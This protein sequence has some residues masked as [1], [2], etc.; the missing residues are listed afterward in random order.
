MT[1]LVQLASSPVQPARL[2]T[3]LRSSRLPWH[4]NCLGISVSGRYPC[5]HR[6][7][8]RGY[9]RCS[10]S[11]ELPRRSAEC[12]SERSSGP[13]IGGGGGRPRVRAGAGR[14][15]RWSRVPD[16]IQYVILSCGRLSALR[17]LGST[18]SARKPVSCSP[19]RR[20]AAVSGQCVQNTAFQSTSRAEAVDGS[21]EG[22]KVPIRPVWMVRSN[23]GTEVPMKERRS[24][25]GPCVLGRVTLKVY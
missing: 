21:N 17:K 4:L 7:G 6:C 5:H 1:S 13:A 16:G 11:Q 10:V 15:P 2:C 9:V 23:E 8:Q 22:T 19:W 14:C 20:R 18:N 12:S 25:S 3:M 24:P